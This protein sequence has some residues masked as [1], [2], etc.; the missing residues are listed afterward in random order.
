MSLF[1]ERTKVNNDPYSGQSTSRERSL[2]LFA[3][4]TFMTGV[5]IRCLFMLFQ[6]K[7]KFLATVSTTDLLVWLFFRGLKFFKFSAHFFE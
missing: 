1:Q 6:I 3:V 7:I 5:L 2:H 4:V